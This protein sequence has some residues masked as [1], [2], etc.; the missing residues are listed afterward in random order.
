[1]DRFEIRDSRSDRKIKPRIMDLIVNDNGEKE[2]EVK[3]GKHTKTIL[4]DDFRRQVDEIES[5]IR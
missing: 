5:H 3:D 2:I 4:L 1:M